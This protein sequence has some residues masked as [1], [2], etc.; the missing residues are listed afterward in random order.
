MDIVEVDL[1]EEYGKTLLHAVYVARF[2]LC[3]SAG[4]FLYASDWNVFFVLAGHGS[5]GGDLATTEPDGENSF[6]D[7]SAC[8]KVELGNDLLYSQ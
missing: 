2:I 7:V 8:V 5:V 6:I 1:E 4:W 3:C